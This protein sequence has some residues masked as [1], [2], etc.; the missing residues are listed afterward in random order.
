[1]VN[2]N[3]S[4]TLKKKELRKSAGQRGAVA[5]DGGPVVERC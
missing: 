5:R 2:A 1:M 3:G 4:E